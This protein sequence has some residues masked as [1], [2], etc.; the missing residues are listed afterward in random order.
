MH[1]NTHDH[2]PGTPLSAQPEPHE[3]PT[4]RPRCPLT[5]DPLTTIEGP[6]AVSEDGT[7][8]AGTE[9]GLARFDG[10]QWTTYRKHSAH[11]SGTGPVSLAVDEDG[12]V[13][14]GTVTEGLWRFDAAE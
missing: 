4:R 9:T 11:R 14:A 7:L 6:L 12:T 8:W 3:P 1:P 10:E 5:D 2:T 13:W